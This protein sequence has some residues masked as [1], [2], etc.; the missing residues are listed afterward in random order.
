MKYEYI[1]WNVTL[2]LAMKYLNIMFHKAI[3][4][5]RETEE[6]YQKSVERAYK[7]WQI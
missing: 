1:K 3:K 5:Q 7:K 4:H 2:D 6:E